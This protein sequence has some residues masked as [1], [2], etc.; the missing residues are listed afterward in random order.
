MLSRSD[1][2]IHVSD[3]DAKFFAR[4]LPQLPHALALPPIAEQPNRAETAKWDLLFVGSSNIPNLK[5]V[6]WYFREASAHYAN[7]PSLAIVGSISGMVADKDAQLFGTRS[8]HFLGSVAD[9]AP[10]YAQSRAV[11]VPMVSGR[12]ISIKTIEAFAHGKPVVGTR[13]AFR[14]IPETAL[15]EHGI[16]HWDAPAEFA[17]AVT[18]TLDNLEEHGER[19]R[20]LYKALFTFDHFAASMT[21]VLQAA[22]IRV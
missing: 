21:E 6:Q 19:S 22:G 4:E 5:A 20:R 3:D 18:A 13:L 11:L 10:Y 17:G 12:G 14:G 2:L 9:P 1:S 16:Q 7:E 15:R 8:R